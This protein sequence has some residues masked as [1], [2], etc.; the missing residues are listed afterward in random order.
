[1]LEDTNIRFIENFKNSTIDIS[2]SG[3]YLVRSNNQLGWVIDFT[4]RE[5]INHKRF[6]S[7][8]V[9]GITLDEKFCLFTSK[10]ETRIDVLS[11]LTLEKVASISTS[12][13]LDLKFISNDSV[14]FYES[15]NTIH[16]SFVKIWN[17]KTG[18]IQNIY[19][20][21]R[22]SDGGH[23]GFFDKDKFVI[24]G[25]KDYGEAITFRIFNKSNSK[26]FRIKEGYEASRF[27]QLRGTKLLV[28]RRE[29]NGSVGIYDIINNNYSVIK[30][31]N[32]IHLRWITDC[33]FWFVELREGCN[34]YSGIMDLSGNT[35]WTTVGLYRFVNSSNDK[36]LIFD[37]CGDIL[38]F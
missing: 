37:S 24:V 13:I 12:Y 6:D 19:D 3:K 10:G 15:N 4:T 25:Q 33:L 30:K 36:Y 38:L 26:S 11:L 14:M 34:F 21:D 9:R 18:E 5:I 1:M 27:S 8:I 7:Y 32:A 16:K 23:S 20:Y 28:S 35:L 17:F 22:I 29:N 31:I 2:Q